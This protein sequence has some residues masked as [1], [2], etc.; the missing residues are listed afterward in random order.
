MIQVRPDLT[1]S[2][3][4]QF[5]S[6]PATQLHHVNQDIN[7]KSRGRYVHVCLYFVYISNMRGREGG[8]EGGRGWGAT[9]SV[10]C[11]HLR[12][13]RNTN[14]FSCCKFSA[15]SRAAQRTIWKQQGWMLIICLGRTQGSLSL[16]FH[17]SMWN[18]CARR[19]F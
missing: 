8:T 18:S 3:A 1:K 11:P 6:T 4:M 12:Y 9:R 5:G 2:R 13:Y 7:G 16:L 15:P 14:C 19:I 10:I 17:K